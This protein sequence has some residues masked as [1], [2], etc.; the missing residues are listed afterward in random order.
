[1]SDSLQHHGLPSPW[2]SPGQNTGAGSLSLLQGIF[3][4][5]GSNSG[6][7]HCGLILYQLSHEGIGGTTDQKAAACQKHEGCEK[8]QAWWRGRQTHLIAWSV[9]PARDGSLHAAGQSP[10]QWGP[11]VRGRGDRVGRIR[12]AAGGGAWLAGKMSASASEAPASPTVALNAQVCPGSL[13]FETLMGRD[14][15]QML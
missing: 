15:L 13:C 10:S 1:M 7:P 6:L 4:T 5:Q 2:N 12:P 9:Q 11:A 8:E 14:V 3:P